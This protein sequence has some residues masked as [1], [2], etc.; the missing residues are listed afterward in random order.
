MATVL[1]VD[2]R[3]TNRDLV[4]TVLG[5][6]DHET[7][8][9][10]GGEQALQILAHER[11]DLLIVDVLMPGMDGYE[12]ARAIR[13][14]PT[15]SDIP[16]LFYTANYVESEI[17]QIASAVGVE[18]IVSKSGD[19]SELLDAINDTLGTTP[20][21][22]EPVEDEA[23][24]REH[25]RVVNA[26]LIEKIGELEEAVRLH[27][28]VDAIVAVGDDLSLP[29]I[30]RRI[31][32]AAHTLVS[33]GHTALITVGG[34]GQAPESVQVGGDHSVGHRVE[35]LAA[36][37]PEELAALGYL[38]VPITIGDDLFGNLLLL[39]A[40]G[41]DFTVGDR[42]LLVTLARAAGVAIANSQLY[43]DARRRQAWLAASA[44]VAS[45][46]LVAEPAK[47]YDM[48]AAGARRVVGARVCW[49]EF[50]HGDQVEIVAS[51]GPLAAA[52][53]DSIPL[54]RAVLFGD[55][56]A[57]GQPV[58]LDD[59]YADAR[60]EQLFPQTDVRIGP[61]LGVALTAAGRTFGVLMMANE[62]GGPRFTPL[63]VEMARAYAGRSAQTL[64]FARADDDRRRLTVLEDRNR[65]AR[66]L[67]DV[68]IQRLFGLGLRL[69]RLRG[70]LPE[71]EARQLGE[72]NID[73]DETI[74]QIRNTI[75]SLRITP[76]SRFSVRAEVLKIVQPMTFLLT[77][78]PRVRFEGTVDNSVPDDV[79]PHLLA[80]L[81]EAL[82]NVV[83]H[84][85]ATQ[86][87]V[88]L[89][90]TETELALRVADNGCGIPVA[91][92]ESGL[93]NLRRR[94]GDLGGSMTIEVA[95]DGRGTV[96]LWSVPV[97]SA[98]GRPGVRHRAAGFADRPVSTG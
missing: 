31:A 19:L 81:S 43:D 63:D 25:L 76:E 9:A 89:R 30:L 59:A 29:A 97:G 58:V 26:K 56:S 60:L 55:I 86:V 5:Y 17:R 64:E 48:V 28:M 14:D 93:T 11:P 23:F 33:S 34:E 57:T 1:I 80:T 71:P 22:S 8:E 74:D 42:S 67:H 65:I 82:S 44:D 79:A 4:S 84:A 88:L 47:A 77:F 35:A 96:L 53:P 54:H 10:E 92:T 98:Q 50:A 38:I 85:Q 62:Q 20:I 12:L 15:T 94:A 83:R 24:D 51:D 16:V 72:I 21:P 36:L 32:S 49:V 46:L 95:S 52:L 69:E 18:R 70:H 37:R 6:H 87:D 41:T 27:R 2:D 68:V 90:A 7:I 40:D 3:Q 91:R 75:F 61:L 73:L 66:D 39:R 13:A 45:T 78:A